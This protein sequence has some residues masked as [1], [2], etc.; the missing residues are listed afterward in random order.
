MDWRNG[1]IR[2]FEWHQNS[3][4]CAICLINDCIY[5]YSSNNAFVPLLKHPLQR[6]VTA[7]SWRPNCDD[8]LGVSC[9]SAIL[10][11]TIDPNSKLYR[12]PNDCIRIIKTCITSPL[13]SMSF[14][15][16]GEYLAT[17]S[18]QSSKL[19]LIKI[20][21]NPEEV[22]TI[23][24]FGTCFGKLFWSSDKTRLLSTTT[25]KY[26]RVFENKCWSSNKWGKQFTGICQ[27]ACWSRPNGRILLVAPR[28]CLKVYA[29]P[30]YDSPEPN[31]VGGTHNCF[32]VLD[33]S[34][35]EFPNGIKVGGSVHDMVWDKYSERLAISFKGLYF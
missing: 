29:I 13:T 9:E 1:L 20:D 21:S 14:D 23:R 34:Q 25:S 2:A 6:K 17:C 32:E 12:P 33:V 10:I 3:N 19:T 4:K 26:I 27:S 28:N 7:L 22:K 11:W 30:F 35:H 8:V 24:H 31:D 16:N 5:V 18:P 15:M